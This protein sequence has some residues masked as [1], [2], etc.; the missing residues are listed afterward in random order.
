MTEIPPEVKAYNDDRD[1][2]GQSPSSNCSLPLLGAITIDWPAHASELEPGTGSMA[3][4]DEHTRNQVSFD[5]LPTVAF[6][7]REILW[8]HGWILR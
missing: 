4:L 7:D 5:S 2:G 1:E 8:M 3:V 6:N